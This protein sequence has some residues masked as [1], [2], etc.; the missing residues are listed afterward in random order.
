MSTT[1]SHW[2]QKE[3]FKYKYFVA[4]IMI[5]LIFVISVFSSCGGRCRSDIYNPR[6]LQARFEGTFPEP[7][8][9]G[10]FPAMMRKFA[11]EDCSWWWGV[12]SDLQIGPKYVPEW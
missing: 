9:S 4:A 10:T 6:N 3:N 11:T 7:D 12:E 2:K 5:S 8:Q 1:K